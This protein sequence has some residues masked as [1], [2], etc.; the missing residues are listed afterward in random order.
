LMSALG[1]RRRKA[2]D[3]SGLIVATQVWFPDVSSFDPKQ[4]ISLERSF[5][6]A[7]FHSSRFI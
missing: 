6:Q 7:S 1:R 2:S 3:P 4:K 5:F